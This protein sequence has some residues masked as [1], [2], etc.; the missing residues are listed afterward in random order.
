MKCS[1]ECSTVLNQ[2]GSDPSNQIIVADTPPRARARARVRAVPRESCACGVRR[3][4]AAG[5]QEAA[6]GREAQ[7]RGRRAEATRAAGGTAGEAAQRANW[8]Q[9][10]GAPHAI[11]WVSSTERWHVRQLVPR[12][13]RARG[14]GSVH[15]RSQSKAHL[16][17][18]FC[19]FLRCGLAR[20]RAALAWGHK[21]IARRIRGPIF[22]VAPGPREPRS[23]RARARLEGRSCIPSRA[24]LRLF[25]ALRVIPAPRGAGLRIV[26]SAT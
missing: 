8:R 14:V 3:A 19:F 4:R 11:C 21:G 9:R 10:G 20:T 26:R 25:I 16:T 2:P 15:A 17:F 24:A 6:G 18:A 22:T 12:A 23:T 7:R 13:R 5:V 1:L